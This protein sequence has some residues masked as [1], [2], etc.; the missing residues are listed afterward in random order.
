VLVLLLVVVG[1]TT[2]RKTRLTWVNGIAHNMDHMEEG[3]L[4]IQ[5]KFGGKQVLFCY[6]PTAMND[7]DDLLGYVNDLTQAGTQKF[8][9]I[10]EEVDVLVQ[11]LREAVAAV[12]KHG[13]V[14]HIAHSQGALLTALAAKQLSVQEM[15]QME[16]LAFGGA[17]ALRRTVKTPFSRCVNYYSIND[18]LL[19][20]VPQAA[21]ALRSGF[22]GDEE[23]CF[24]APRIGD[25]I[26]DHNLVGPTYL[27]ALTWEGRRFQQTYQSVAH[28]TLRP[29]WL[30]CLTLWQ[31]FSARL[32]AL[33]KILLKPL[34]LWSLLVWMWTRTM[35][36]TAS[37]WANA[38]VVQPA[39]TIFSLLQ[40]W[41]IIAL[42]TWRGEEQYVPVAPNLDLKTKQ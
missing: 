15:S 29:L 27:Q 4:A 31:A 36:L 7:E 6:N 33:L 34:I 30:L 19:F 12:G 23:W 11:H 41:F 16:V 10:T 28:R 25:P 1:S 5:E 26:R 21:Q 42:R 40:E 17:A 35:I 18:P 3:R 38:C 8:G 14:I 39:R 37:K 24:L 2:A 13:R 9:R 32:H 22:V 20:V